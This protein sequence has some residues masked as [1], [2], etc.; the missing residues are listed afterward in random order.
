MLIHPRQKEGLRVLEKMM[1]N[2]LYLQ[3]DIGGNTKGRKYQSRHTTRPERVRLK[4]SKRS[5]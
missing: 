1:Q 4:T 5:G 2:V 3:H